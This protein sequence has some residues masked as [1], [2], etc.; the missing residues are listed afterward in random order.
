[1]KPRVRDL[2][3]IA[4]LEAKMDAYKMDAVVARAPAGER[5]AA[6]Q[7]LSGRTVRAGRFRSPGRG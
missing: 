7:A 3:N 6:V 2:V 4:R 1:M 5:L